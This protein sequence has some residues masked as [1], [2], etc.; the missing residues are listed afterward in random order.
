MRGIPRIIQTPTDLQNLFAMAQN[1]EL[2][3]KSLA[4]RCNDLLAKQY[5][6][7]PILSADGAKITTYYFPECKV[8]TTTSEGLTVKS[9]KHIE[10]P[11]PEGEGVQYSQTEITLSKAP[12]DKAT[13]S[14]LLDDNFLKHN[15][16]DL[17]ELNYI[18]GVLAR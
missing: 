11:E 18:R 2:D 6:T 14:I 12:A 3:K 7:V 16:F 4:S 17:D 10:D 5:H 15:K 1:G 13:L 8:N 9:V